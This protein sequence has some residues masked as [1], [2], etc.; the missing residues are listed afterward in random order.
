MLQFATDHAQ[1]MVI[2]A[3]AKPIPEKNFSG[4]IY[5]RRVAKA[6]ERRLAAFFFP[7]GF[8]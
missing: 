6:A 7:D 5:L 2:G 4:K 8:L 1:V 3:V